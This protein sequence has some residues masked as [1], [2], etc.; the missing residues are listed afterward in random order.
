MPD[1]TITVKTWN[2]IRTRGVPT[3]YTYDKDIQVVAYY[4]DTAF[5]ITLNT[6]LAYYGKN[7]IT[8]LATGM[9]LGA[10]KR[11]ASAREYIRRVMLSAFNWNDFTTPD[12]FMEHA[13]FFINICRIMYAEGNWE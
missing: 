6:N 13:E 4:V 1:T 9:T 7:A 11:R 5:A 3:T 8:H 10:W 12:T 2:T